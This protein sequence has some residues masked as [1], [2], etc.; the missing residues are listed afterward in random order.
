VSGSR[1][2]F[3]LIPRRPVLALSVGL[4]RSVRR[5]VGSDVAGSKPYRP[6]DDIHAIDWAASARLSTARG[7]DEFI[8]RERF[9][10][11]APKIVIVCDRRPAM[12][13]PDASLPW[14][15]KAAAMRRAVELVLS[16][17]G[18]SGGYVG[19][20]D[21]A[22]GEPHWRPPKGERKLLELR[23]PRL[24][25]SEYDGPP[26]W[27]E[28]SVAHLA[29]YPRAITSGTFVFVFSD[30]IPAPPR[31]TWL[32][33]EHHPWDVVPVVIQDPVWEQS[34]PDVSGIVVPLRDSQTGKLR[35]VRLTSSEAAERKAANEERLGEL[36]AT[37]GSVDLD[38]ILISSSGREQI[39]SEFLVWAAVRRSGR[40]RKH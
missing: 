13:S 8:V 10:E 18:A 26:D 33:A 11:E 3:P 2:T 30:F 5:G 38:P 32:A 40:G 22:D 9:A 28:R 23:D 7:S 25:S 19:Y 37:F 12:A 20:L 39:L 21:Y 35:P 31:E 24:W 16:S 6:G 27:L 15:D 17:A 4:T 34:F 29:S 1:L 14:L 36:M